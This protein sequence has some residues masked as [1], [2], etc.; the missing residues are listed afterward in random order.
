MAAAR[1]A[2]EAAPEREAAGTGGSGGGA[3]GGTGGATDGGK[4]EGGGGDTPPSTGPGVAAACQQMVQAANAFIATIA[5]E[6]AKRSQAVLAFGMRRHFKYTPGD[7]PGLPLM[8]MTMPQRDAALALVK[9]GLSTSG[10]TKA[11][12]V[13]RMEIVLDALEDG[14]NRDPLRYFVAIYGT[15]AADGDWAW[16]WEGHHLS[17]HFTLSKCTAV[18]DAPTF[19][20]TSPARVPTNLP[21]GAQGAPAAGT[22]VLGKE[23]DLARALAMTL[24]GDAQKRGMAIV[25]NQLREVQ[26]SPARVTP[27]TPAGLAASAMSA[28]EQDQ[29]KAVIAEYA[30]SMSPDLAAARL[31]R[32]Q[33][34]GFDK[35]TFLWSGSLT[36]GQAHYYRIQ[37]PTFLVE[38]LNQ[39]NAA[40]HIHSVWRDFN[41]DFGEDLLMLHLKEYPH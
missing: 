7:R 32:L 31:K 34:A 41:G 19:Y 38:Y 8:A 5:G 22:R 40:N 33:D 36:A 28:A 18:A 16:H 27:A 10:Y 24:S 25:A 39:Q 2:G 23:E 26:D 13:R 17:L 30:Q 35:T 21:G 9:T 29:L 15:P 11:E 4:P 14:T 3:S 37:G 6:P 20:G 12:D 1:A